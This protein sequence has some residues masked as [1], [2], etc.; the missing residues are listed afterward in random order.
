M[1]AERFDPPRQPLS[2]DQV[3]KSTSS[4]L[5]EFEVLRFAQREVQD[6]AWVRPAC[7]EASVKYYKL[8]RAREEVKRLNL[9]VRRL[10]VSIDTEI[11]HTVKV[12]EEIST[13]NPLLGIELKRRWRARSLINNLHLCKLAELRDQ[14]YFTGMRWDRVNEEGEGVDEDASDGESESER[15]REFD[16]MTEFIEG[17]TD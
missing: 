3:T 14:V 8:C 6:K 17:I 10:Q 13:Q 7:R 4:F 12:L 1:Q 16:T 5:A 9:E 2:L 11:T 15:E